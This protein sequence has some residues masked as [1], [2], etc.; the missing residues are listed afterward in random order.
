MTNATGAIIF[1]MH[2]FIAPQHVRGPIEVSGFSDLIACEQARSVILDDL[3]A[4]MFRYMP[5]EG[6]RATCVGVQ[7]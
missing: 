5:R 6:M 3:Q 2:V 4:R 7:R 1:V